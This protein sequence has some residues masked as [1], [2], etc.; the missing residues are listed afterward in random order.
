MEGLCWIVLD[1]PKHAHAVRGS[2]RGSPSG[3]EGTDDKTEGGV[4][5]I[6]LDE[7]QRQQPQ[8][9]LDSAWKQPKQTS[10]CILL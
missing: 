8:F 9:S 6:P 3:E 4:P 10:R 1:K 7:H 5:T 2:G